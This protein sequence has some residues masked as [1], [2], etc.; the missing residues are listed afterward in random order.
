MERFQKIMKKALYPPIFVVCLTALSFPA[1]I[2]L[3]WAGK[4]SSWFSYP[5]YVLSAYA[6]TVVSVRLVPVLIRWAKQRRQKEKA[7][8]AVPPEQRLQAQEMGLWKNLTMSLGYGVF[9]LISGYFQHSVWLGTNGLYNLVQGI[10]YGI[11]LRYQRKLEKRYD[12]RYAWKGY[13]SIG[14]WLMG[15]NLTMTG[16]V[17]LVIWRGETESYP[18]VLVFAVAAMTFYKLV[19]SILA[20]IRYR[21]NNSP[22]LGAAC[23]ANHTEAI[24][25]TFMLQT[26]LFSAFGQGFDY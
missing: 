5:I 3:F 20:L 25:S 7:E 11:L 17:F 1:L 21:R 18:G 23:N 12:P 26:A 13:T 9:Y 6:L 22:I 16:C 24:M 10:A 4:E 8:E 14:W 19:S 15:V 2:W